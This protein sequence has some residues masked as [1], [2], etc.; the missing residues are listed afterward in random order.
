MTLFSRNGRPRHRVVV[1]GMGVITP[2]GLTVETY[3]E[4][5]LAGRSGAGTITRFDAS[6]YPTR[7]ACEVKDFD[8]LT[9]VDK[10]EARRLDRA[11][12]LA[13]GATREAVVSAGLD[14][15]RLDRERCG[16]VI[17][18]GIGGIDTFENQ[19]RLLMTQGPGRVS[20]F[21]IPMMIIDMSAGMVSL[22][23]G[24]KG[25]NYATVSACA[26]SAHAITDAARLIERGD[27]DLMITGGAEATITPASLAGFCSARAMS[28]RND[29][30][31]K[32]SRPFDANRDGFVM[33][34]GAGILILESLEHA[35]KRGA[36]VL[37][38]ILGAGMSADAYHITA[39]APQGEGAARSMRAALK[40]A[41]IGTSDVDYVN[42][43]GT[44]TD[45]GD[46]SET[47][48]IR[49]VFGGHAD[50]LITNSTKSMVGHLLGAAGGVEMIACV[51][52]LQ[53]GKIHPTINLETPDPKCD[54]N[55]APNRLV[56]RPIRV[57][58]SNSF[59]FGG[60]NATVV[61]ARFEENGIV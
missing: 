30:P 12:L 37:C 59:G 35:T 60:H 26:S 5:L 16:V 22:H 33:G 36:P 56:E 19:H 3:W 41:G 18:S 24:L 32:A 1:T 10:K 52:S 58:I 25:P 51:K 31:E 23:Y 14:F 28:T 27:A 34:E 45:L 53:T 61:A 48:A 44:A 42:T 9:V 46:I 39:P 21:F 50:R 54:L 15:D 43:H 57:A 47:E 55:Y 49:S 2:I 7:I 38:E 17:G 6:Q 4:S 20:P 13:L 29:E 11:Q 8:P 40:D